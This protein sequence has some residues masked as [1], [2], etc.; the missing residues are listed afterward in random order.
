MHTHLLLVTQKSPTPKAN[1]GVSASPWK[2]E[3]VTTTT[4]CFGESR[5]RTQLEYQGSPGTPGDSGDSETEGNDEDWSHN[6]HVPTN[7]VLHMEKVF[8][9]VRQRH[10]RSPTD[11]MTAIWCAFLSVGFE[12]KWYGSH[13]PKP[14]GECDKTAEDMMVNFVESGHPVFRATNALERGEL[15]IKKQRKMK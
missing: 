3:Q 11:Q 14:D 4:D 2:A 7:C 6:L 10:G 12:K 1:Q 9:I 5:A 8:S 15:R 13:L